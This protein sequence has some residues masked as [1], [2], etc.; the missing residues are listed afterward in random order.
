[1]VAESAI[2]HI[3]LAIVWLYGF[4][5]VFCQVLFYLLFVVYSFCIKIEYR[6]LL[7]PSMEVLVIVHL[8][9]ILF[10]F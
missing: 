6:Q 7:I 10:D 2:E 8:W 3:L 4:K 1:M 5:R 9:D